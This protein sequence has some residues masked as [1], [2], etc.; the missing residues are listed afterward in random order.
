MVV[1]IKYYVHYDLNFSSGKN[2]TTLSSAMKYQLC[3]AF[4]IANVVQLPVVSVVIYTTSR[5]LIIFLGYCMVNEIRFPPRVIFFFCMF[6][7]Y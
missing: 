1:T 4:K 7:Y 6:I 5:S 2:L 3:S